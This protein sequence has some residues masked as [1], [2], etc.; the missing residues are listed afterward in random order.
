MA[1]EFCTDPDGLPCFPQYGI[2]PHLYGTGPGF[3]IGTFFKPREFWPSNFQEDPENPNHGT[4]W[5]PECGDGK[6]KN[7]PEK[8][9]EMEINLNENRLAELELLPNT[10]SPAV[11]RE[12][13]RR[14]RTAES[15]AVKSEHRAIT[16]GDLLHER[17]IVM[18]AAVVAGKLE[19]LEQGLQWIVNTLEGPGHLPNLDEARAI[20][21]AQAMF[22]A[23]MA[24]H[25]AFRAAHPAPAI[26]S[27][28]V[29]DCTEVKPS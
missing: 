16:Y 4:Y 3:R 17:I 9:T 8:A 2:A 19:G 7:E 23:E 22:D 18:R 10:A 27:P 21:G 24:E 13:V 25:E 12:L 20:G 26:Q 11:V 6:P 29:G 14:L 15:E 1:C 28:R 5:C